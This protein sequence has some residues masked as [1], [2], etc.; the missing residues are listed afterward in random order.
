MDEGKHFGFSSILLKA[1]G[2]MN[3]HTL[4]SNLP[5]YSFQILQ[6]NDFQ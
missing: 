4:F 6:Q 1:L 2:L 3:E 5:Y